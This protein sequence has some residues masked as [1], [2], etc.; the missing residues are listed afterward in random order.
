MINSYLYCCGL[1]KCGI[2]WFYYEL[3]C[4]VV[5]C[6]YSIVHQNIYFITLNYISALENC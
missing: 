1:A 5:A 6:R 4:T 2:A 3:N